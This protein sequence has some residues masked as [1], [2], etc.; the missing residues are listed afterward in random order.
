MKVYTLISIA[1]LAVG[2]P[3]TLAQEDVGGEQLDTRAA[4]K[5]NQYRTVED[6]KNDKHILYHKAPRSG[7]C[8]KIDEKTGSFFYNTGG[9]RSALGYINDNCKGTYRIYPAGSDGCQSIY[10]RPGSSID[11]SQIRSFAMS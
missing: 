11:K 10:V 7:E 1:L 3:V 2:V 8:I 4:Q 9:L 5:F 6:C